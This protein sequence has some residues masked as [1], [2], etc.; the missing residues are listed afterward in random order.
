MLAALT[1]RL[2]GLAAIEPL[3]GVASVGVGIAVALFA[4]QLL[5]RLGEAPSRAGTLKTS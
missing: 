2:K 5:G 4:W 1:A 3:I